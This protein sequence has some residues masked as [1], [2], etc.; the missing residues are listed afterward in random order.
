MNNAVVLPH[1]TAVRRSSV[2][3]QCRVMNRCRLLLGREGRRCCDCV[4]ASFGGM[5]Q[6]L[7][8]CT[9]NSALIDSQYW[10]KLL[11]VEMQMKSCVFGDRWTLQAENYSLAVKIHE[12]TPRLSERSRRRVG[13]DARVW[14]RRGVFLCRKISWLVYRRRGGRT[15]RQVQWQWW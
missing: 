4:G 3:F 7:S 6:S 2:W 13:F 12:W 15:N 10:R 9:L 14:I 11:R 1:S 8:R 5:N